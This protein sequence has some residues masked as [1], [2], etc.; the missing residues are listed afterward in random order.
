MTLRKKIASHRSLILAAELAGLLHDVGK[1]SSAFLCYRQEWRRRERGWNEDPHD[2]DFLDRYD[3]LLKGGGYNLVQKRLNTPLSKLLGYPSATFPHRD[4]Y[5]APRLR[6]GLLPARLPSTTFPDLDTYTIKGLVHRHTGAKKDEPDSDLDGLIG[7]LHAADSIDAAQDRNNP[8]FSANQIGPV[9]DAD[10]FGYEDPKDALKDS[11]SWKTLDDRRAKLYC[12]LETL[13]QGLDKRPLYSHT[14]R[15][16]FLK[17]LK[18]AFHPAGAFG[19]T[20]RPAND[21]SLWE[22]SYAVASLF[23]VLVLHKIIYGE[24]LS[25]FPRVRFAILGV[26]WD[27]LGFMAQGQKIADILARRDLIRRVAEDIQKTVEYDFCL[28]NC[29]YQ[30]DSSLCFIIPSLE[31]E[32]Q[33]LR[34][35]ADHYLSLLQHQD[36]DAVG[37]FG[38]T[39]CQRDYLKCLWPLLNRI[40]Q[41]VAEKSAGDLQPKFALVPNTRFTTQIVRCLDELKKMTGYPLQ[42]V[43]KA[44]AQVL[45]EKAPSGQAR[46][47]C[48]ACLRRTVRTDRREDLC[49]VCWDR[50]WDRGF[51][52]HVLGDGRLDETKVRDKLQEEET[53]S[54]TPFVAD[55][56]LA[57]ARGEKPTRPSESTG[58]P[59]SAT[60]AVAAGPADAAQ[61]MPKNANGD[62]ERESGPRRAALIVAKFHLREWLSGRM[63]RT[64]FVTSARGLDQE[65]ADLGNT[66]Q[67]VREEKEVRQWLETSPCGDL[68]RQGYDYQRIQR[69]IDLSYGYEGKTAEE[70]EYAKNTVFLYNQRVTGD[71]ARL[72]REPKDAHQQWDEWK[73]DAVEEHGLE[74]GDTSALLY[75]LLCGKTPTPSTV[76]DIWDTTERFFTEDVLS[77]VRKGVRT[78]RRWAIRVPKPDK[79]DRHAAYEGVVGD[80]PVK[81]VG[82]TPVEVAWVTDGLV[83]VIGDHETVRKAIRDGARQLTVWE[84]ARNVGTKFT[85]TIQK[86]EQP[87]EYHPMR[88]I[89]T[90]PDML[91]VIVPADKA[92]EVTRDIYSEYVRRFGKVAGRLPFSIGNLFF[93]E[94]TPMFV[95]LDAARRMVRNFEA[96]AEKPVCLRVARDHSWLPDRLEGRPPSDDDR[97]LA[98]RIDQ[99]RFPDGAPVER[100][101]TWRMPYRLG[102]GRIDYYHAYVRVPED[103]DS[104]YASRKGYFRTIRGDVIHATEV[105]AGDTLEVYP[106]YYDFEF[107][108][109]SARRFD[110]VGSGG[111]RK[112]PVDRFMSRPYLLEELDQGLVRLWAAMKCQKPLDAAG[113]L[114]LLRPGPGASEPNQEQTPLE[115]KCGLP[116]MPGLTDT[117]LRNIESLWLAK[118]QEWRVDPSCRTNKAFQ[119]WKDLVLATLQK[120]FPPEASATP[121]QREAHER[122]VERL[123]E[124]I[125]SGLFFD[126]LELHLRILKDRI[127]RKE[128]P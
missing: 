118:L 74:A 54:G 120:E 111:R 58:G 67:F 11:K 78:R 115:R 102:D 90:S 32:A 44:F 70:Q 2:H 89:T 77:G 16:R 43:D 1:L 25:A 113:G 72:N 36:L 123:K 104:R 119:Q 57:S 48:P 126:C 34:C 41:E 99:V 47:V 127:G 42:H 93:E 18:C 8:L 73:K 50:R 128:G 56:A 26:G 112:G 87:Y 105:Q 96:L 33:P 29:V 9:Y 27:A 107:L 22:H 30:D 71:P 13:L 6:K 109:S 117:Q 82:D 101:L 76:L 37:D 62:G 3:G 38:L 49:Q 121:E 10:I 98:I 75:N 108:D 24:T 23:R 53:T 110:L 114:R 95:V 55:I 19:D 125:F 68:V 15:Q 5:T 63:V 40:T 116:L 69:E 14:T 84:T 28:G 100:S 46:D 65:V 51:F 88:V 64:T 12:E 86:M 80:T 45:A 59:A 83:L 79:L 81:V 92:V 106:N 35:T 7:M 31:P 103:L 85:R 122:D 66:R 39:P 61:E 17:A 124:A 94:H 4:T 60:D 21:A 20:T 97:K 52:H 91:M